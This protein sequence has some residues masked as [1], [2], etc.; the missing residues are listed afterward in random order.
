MHGISELCR[1]PSSS[2][3]GAYARIVLDQS[4][5]RRLV[6]TGSKIISFGGDEDSTQEKIARAQELV[7]DLTKTQKTDDKDSYQATK[8]FAEWMKR[9]DSETK[10]GFLCF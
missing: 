9:T 7:S 1:T 4:N 10:S 5:L 8:E 6:D 2:N 3:A